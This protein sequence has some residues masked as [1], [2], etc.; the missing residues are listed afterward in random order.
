LR[1]GKLD[2]EEP[3]LQDKVYFQDVLPVVGNILSGCRVQQVLMREQVLG[4]RRLHNHA[5]QR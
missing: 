4:L 3:P 2:V 1:L 5:V